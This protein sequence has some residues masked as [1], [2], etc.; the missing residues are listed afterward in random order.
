MESCLGQVFWLVDLPTR[1]AFPFRS[2]GTVATSV[3]FV[4][5]YSGGAAT[6]SHRLPYTHALTRFYVTIYE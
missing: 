3:V 4:P 2:D 1:H 5:T 6:A